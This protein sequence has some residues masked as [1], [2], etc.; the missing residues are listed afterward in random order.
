MK[1]YGN[2]QPSKKEMLDA[3]PDPQMLR[4]TVQYLRFEER[5]AVNKVLDEEQQERLQMLNLTAKVNRKN[6]SMVR[7][8][9]PDLN[10]TSQQ[11]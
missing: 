5:D 9:K 11:T 10:G 4:E 6:E 7:H 2:L 3:N 8:Q 1:L